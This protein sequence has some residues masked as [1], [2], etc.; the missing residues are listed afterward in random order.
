MSPISV[1]TR[2]SCGFCTCMDR[3]LMISKGRSSL[4]NRFWVKNNGPGDS[5][6]FSSQMI[7]N[8]GLRITRPSDAIVTSRTRR[9][10]SSACDSDAVLCNNRL[11]S[12]A[13]ALDVRFGHAGEQRQRNQPVVSVFRHREIAPLPAKGLAVVGVVMNRDEVHR[14]PDAPLPQLRHKLVPVYLQPLRVE[15]YRVQVP[16]M[17][18][19]R[20][21]N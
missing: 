5:M 20:P 8:K 15:P 6:R 4:P 9:L 2:C 17:V 19:L 3:N 16:G 21:R 1:E 10:R 14:R 13:D 12:N 18:D 7:A 11:D